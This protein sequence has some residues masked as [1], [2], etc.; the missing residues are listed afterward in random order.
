MS[1]PTEQ[2]NEMDIWIHVHVQRFFCHVNSYN[3]KQNNSTC[4][5]PLDV[6]KERSEQ[7]GLMRWQCQTGQQNTADILSLVL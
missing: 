4:L 6:I 5:P 7:I 2:E 1:L 3:T